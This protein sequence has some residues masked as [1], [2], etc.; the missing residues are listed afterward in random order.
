[1]TTVIIA[2]LALILVSSFF[3]G[4]ETGLISL[5]V[6]KVE[7]ESSKNGR[8]KEILK[9]L[10][11]PSQL[12]GI[13]LLGTN[14]SIVL[15]STISTIYFVH[16]REMISENML[17]LIISGIVLIFAE[18][19]PK[20]IYR[21][22]PEK[23]V[24][25]SFPL[26]KIASF[27]FKPFVWVISKYYKTF[28]HLF[29]IDDTS[30]LITR[31]DL[32][33]FLSRTKNENKLQQFQSE[34]L[35]QTLEF[36]ELK[37]KN[38]MIPR[39]DIVAVKYDMSYDEIVQL[40]VEKGYTRFPV[41]D[42]D[43]D[44]ILGVLIIYDLLKF[45]HS[46]KFNAKNFLRKP[47]VCHE[48]MDLNA[49]LHEMQIKRK[50]LAFIIDSY[51]GTAGLV[52]VEDILEEIVGEIEDEYDVEIK[53]PDIEKLGINTYAVK[54]FIEIDELN[55]DYDFELPEGDYETV[56]GLIIDKLASIPAKGEVLTVDDWEI[57]IIEST[58]KKIEKVKFTKK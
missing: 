53:E 54:G 9:I 43:I 41:Y 17:S 32:S 34:M 57:Q 4:I 38:V 26:F 42:E 3:S 28:S 35:D 48:S 49:L 14:I 10:K 44:N 47:L 37:A 40:A 51:G 33:Y 27:I 8:S 30:D 21:D 58:N 46:K 1:M 15:I 25:I 6:L 16:N 29:K 36:T 12:L 23:M 52:T 2:L 55:S 39:T 56:S 13:T 45:D 20:A 22:F 19:I 5:E 18:I 31:E 11:N 7:K 50:S 24:D